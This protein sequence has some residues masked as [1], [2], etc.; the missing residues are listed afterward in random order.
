MS[1]SEYNLINLHQALVQ[2]SV[3]MLSQPTGAL[4]P[5]NC[6]EPTNFSDCLPSMKSL[7]MEGS[8]GIFHM[9]PII[10]K[11]IPIFCT[12]IPK[13]TPTCQENKFILSKLTNYKSFSYCVLKE[14]GE[15]IVRFLKILS[16]SPLLFLMNNNCFNLS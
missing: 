2:L 12:H 4:N 8:L 7:Y 11:M 16:F 6:T 10:P 13:K 3:L 5:T 15:N 1:Q 9:I 14:C